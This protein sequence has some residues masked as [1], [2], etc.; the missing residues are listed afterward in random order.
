MKIVILK[1]DF[2][3]SL[4]CVFCVFIQCLYKITQIRTL[5]HFD[6][7]HQRNKNIT[8]FYTTRIVKSI[9]HGNYHASMSWFSI[10]TAFDFRRMNRHA[11]TI[12]M[13]TNTFLLMGSNGVAISCLV[14]NSTTD[15]TRC[16]FFHRPKRGEQRDRSH[17]ISRKLITTSPTN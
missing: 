5:Y 8:V 15:N 4:F 16:L 13:P 14:L 17:D 10:Q 6:N 9:Q 2:Y 12:F 7:D 1:N 11:Q 3:S